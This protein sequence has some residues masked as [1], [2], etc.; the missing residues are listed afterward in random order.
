MDQ[1]PLNTYLFAPF[2][3]DL[4]KGYLYRENGEEVELTATPRKIL[5]YMLENTSEQGDTLFTR[6]KIIGGV[7]GNVVV[8]SA[9]LDTSPRCVRHSAAVSATSR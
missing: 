7:W 6:D 9:T 1:K 8:E 4:E 3:L 2:K 5:E